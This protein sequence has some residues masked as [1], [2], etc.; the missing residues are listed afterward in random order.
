MRT[1]KEEAMTTAKEKAMTIQ[2]VAG[3]PAVYG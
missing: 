2:D 3:I 1:E